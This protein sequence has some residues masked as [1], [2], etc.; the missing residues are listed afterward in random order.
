MRKCAAVAAVIALMA[1]AFFLPEVLSAWNDRQLL[2]SLSIETQSEEREGFAESLQLTVAEKL[3]LLRE[4]N[5]VAMELRGEVVQGMNVSVSAP[6]GE[7]F[8]AVTYLEDGEERE[9]PPELKSANEAEIEA[10][11]SEEKELWEARLAAV[12]A[13]VRSLQDMGGL[14]ELW[15]ADAEL[16]YT[17]YGEILYMDAGTQV[18]FQVYHITVSCTPYTLDMMVDVQSGRIL[19]FSL[20]WGWGGSPNWGPR[21]AAGFGPVW[22]NYWGMDMVSSSWYNDYTKSILEQAETKVATNG[23]T[24]AHGQISFTFDGQ[25]VSIPLDCAAYGGRYCA[26][27]W[28]T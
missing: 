24:Q 23:D 1:A 19:S 6:D 14:P 4:G 28:N 10:Y 25:S 15:S 26:I 20:Q 2:N 17:G 27:S 3:L 12:L 5:L 9:L 18:S 16:E 21:G 11:Q 7:A 8:W 13:E 22:R